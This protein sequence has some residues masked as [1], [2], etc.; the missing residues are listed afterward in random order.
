MGEGVATTTVLRSLLELV[1][2]SFV[3]GSKNTWFM[4]LLIKIVDFRA[5]W[6]LVVLCPRENIVV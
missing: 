1:S 5:H 4:K 3:V 2:S 6:Q